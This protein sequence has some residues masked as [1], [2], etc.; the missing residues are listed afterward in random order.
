[1]VWAQRQF[2]RTPA[3]RPR[4]RSIHGVLCVPRDA[5]ALVIIARSAGVQRPTSISHVLARSLRK[6]KLATCLVDLVDP[7][8]AEELSWARDTE[9]LA[10]RL[11]AAVNFVALNRRT[12]GLPLGLVGFDVAAAATLT[13]A[14]RCDDVV[15]S[16][17]AWCGSPLA[18]QFSADD[19]NVPTL[20]LAPS[21]EE[22]LL[23]ENQR[24][25]EKLDCPSQL[26]V[27]LGATRQFE[28]AGT[29]VAGQLTV[30]QWFEQHLRPLAR[31]T[32]GKAGGRKGRH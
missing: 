1:M 17:V 2:L 7:L 12:A 20:L 13:A 15:R 4:T 23:R 11:E 9:F 18:G 3:S 16:A 6:A 31:H 19:L 32:A 25:F 29:L 22:R 14:A 24:T 30:E 27:I 10:E 8:N 21:R 28:E 26:A 5:Y